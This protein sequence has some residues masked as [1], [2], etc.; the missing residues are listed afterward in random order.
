MKL[1]KPNIDKLFNL[2]FKA[3]P[4]I[5]IVIL[6]L[7]LNKQCKATENVT[8]FYH[9]EKQTVELYKNKI[10]TLT[11]TI[12]ASELSEKQLKELILQKN[13][14]LKLLAKE[15]SKVQYVTI[16]KEVIK[17]DS[18]KVPFNVEIPCEFERLGKYDTDTHFKFNYALNQTGLSLSDIEI[19]NKQTIITGT[20]RKWFLGKQTLHAD[21]TN[22][23]PYIQTQEVQTIVVPVQTEWYNNK[24][25]YLG[26]GAVGGVLLSK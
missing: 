17:I 12:N 2:F 14:S 9:N 11:A 5:V 8:K 4:Y 16:I 26:I 20:K 18:V 22:S 1:P 19:P 23:N 24:W 7:L 13:D 25:V 15:F 3:I 10:G 21:I 6:I